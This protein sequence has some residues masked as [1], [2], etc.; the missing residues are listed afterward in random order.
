MVTAS[1]LKR[2]TQ[3]QLTNIFAELVNTHPSILSYQL[4]NNPKDPIS[5]RLSIQGF[6]FVSTELKLTAYKFEVDT[7][8]TNKNLLQLE[9]YFQGMYF[10]LRDKLFVFDETEASMINLMDG[11]IV[12][13]LSN[14]ESANQT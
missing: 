4:W 14:L 13:Y 3:S 8:L 7:P 12:K 10:I 2:Y 1:S 6:R 9:R 5:L 11:N